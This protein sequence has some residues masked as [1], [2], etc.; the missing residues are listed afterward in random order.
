M[1]GG[2]ISHQQG[3]SQDITM[4][5]TTL[6]KNRVMNADDYRNGISKQT[7]GFTSPNSQSFNVIQDICNSE[8]NGSSSN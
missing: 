4:G 8:R 7:V 3:N 6:R 1:T 2:T 5:T